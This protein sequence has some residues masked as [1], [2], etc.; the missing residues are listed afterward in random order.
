[1]YPLENYVCIVEEKQKKKKTKALFISKQDR[2]MYIY[3]Y[4]YC[5]MAF[6][7]LNFKQIFY[8]FT[9]FLKN[10]FSICECILR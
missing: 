9:F 7:S 10:K 2:F 3:I 1:M 6:I 4:V 8:I 5:L